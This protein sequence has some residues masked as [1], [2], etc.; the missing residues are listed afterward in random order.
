MSEKGTRGQGAFLND[1]VLA[2]AER[3]SKWP[4]TGQSAG[5]RDKFLE[6][7]KMTNGEQ[8]VSGGRRDWP[9]RVAGA[10]GAAAC[11]GLSL[12]VLSL[13]DVHLFPLGLI[14]FLA[15]IAVGIFLG[16]RAGSL[17]FR[18]SPDK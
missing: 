12:L 10:I 16:R 6:E 4:T 13:A 11:G 9:D 7:P 3:Y 15:S 14:V 1:K 5:I 18:R 2:R 17:L 8:S